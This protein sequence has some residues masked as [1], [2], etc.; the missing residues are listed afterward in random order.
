M[1]ILRDESLWHFWALTGAVLRALDAS[2]LRGAFPP[3]DLRAVCL[4]RAISVSAG[5]LVWRGSRDEKLDG[6]GKQGV[7]SHSTSRVNAYIPR[8]VTRDTCHYNASA[9]VART[10]RA[11]LGTSTFRIISQYHHCSLIL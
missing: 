10:A 9:A 8:R 4:V 1:S 3:V 11:L 6:R 7:D 5:D 2:C